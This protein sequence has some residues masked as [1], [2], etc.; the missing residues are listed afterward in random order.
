MA[1]FPFDILRSDGRNHDIFPL[2]VLPEKISVG[3]QINRTV[4]RRLQQRV[5][6]SKRVNLAVHSLNSMF[7]GKRR[8][9]QARV[10]QDVFPCLMP[11]E[12][13]W[14]TS[15]NIIDKVKLMG[16]PPPGACRAEAFSALRAAGSSYSEP[17]P[18]IGSV[19]EMNLESLSLPNGNVGGVDLLD[20]LVGKTRDMAADFENHLLED[21]DSWTHI[22]S[23]M[24]AVPPCN[25]TLLSSKTGY[26]KFIKHLY[27]CGVLSF[28][29]SCKGRVG[30][31]C[32][33]KKPKQIGGA[34]I[35]RQRL[36]LD[37]RQTNLLFKPPPL[38][39]LGSLSALSK[40]YPWIR[41]RN[42]GLLEQIFETAFMRSM[43]LQDGP[44]TSAYPQI[45]RLQRRWK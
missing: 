15:F 14:L 11:S 23:E 22:K 25:D 30:A 9:L 7:F 21:A 8:P 43:F 13:L 6:M 37:C 26:L 12:M 32:V 31:F 24:M 20:G 16:G 17:E 40:L 34:L 44:T 33:S 10:V 36:A 19:V 28:T 2:P 1:R 4:Q 39:E 41:M 18:G 5:A 29:S 38:T 27:S 35:E 45:F 42:F 3:K